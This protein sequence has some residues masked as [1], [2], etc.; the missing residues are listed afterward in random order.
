MV[1]VPSSILE[2]PISILLLSE[3]HHQ[4][5]L[6]FPTV[7]CSNHA[8]WLDPVLNLR[9]KINDIFLWQ[10]WSIVVSRNKPWFKP[11]TII[12]LPFFCF[13][14]N[15]GLMQDV[16]GFVGIFGLGGRIWTASWLTIS[17]HPPSKSARDSLL[18]TAVDFA[19]MGLTFSFD[20]FLN[21]LVGIFWGNCIWIW[22]SSA[23]D[24]PKVSRASLYRLDRITSY[25]KYY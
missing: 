2:L 5:V 20:G 6:V 19:D 24:S 3:T 18:P 22:Y 13:S 9:R 17:Q 8:I 4:E 14:L 21:V 7:F 15:V 23:V 10:G 12:L 16:V 1:F 25:E 11:P